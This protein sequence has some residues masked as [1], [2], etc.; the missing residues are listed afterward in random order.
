M[1]ALALGV[2]LA[3]AALLFVVLNVGQPWMKGHV[4]G[5]VADATGLDV[6][7]RD[8]SLSFPHEL[9]V[10]GLVVRSPAQVRAHAPALLRSGTVR[11][12][13]AWAGTTASLRALSADAV[14]LALVTDE[15]GRSSL[16]FVGAPSREPAS[17]LSRQLEELLSRLPAERVRLADVTLEHVRVERGSVVERDVAEHLALE[18]TLE[19]RATGGPKLR[20]RLSAPALVLRRALHAATE[21][22]ASLTASLRLEATG[23][24]AD[25]ALEVHLTRQT[26]STEVPQALHA[27]LVARAAFDPKRA[28]TTVQLAKLVVGQGVMTAQAALE[29]PDAG[30]AVITSTQGE[31]DVPRLLALLPAWLVPLQVERGQLRFRTPALQ[32][33]APVPSVVE[34]E[35][36]LS[37]LRMPLA[38]DSLT[39]ERIELDLR[40]R[41]QDA[42]MR[43]EGDMLVSRA[44][45]EGTEL[46]L[47][48]ETLALSVAVAWDADFALTGS[49]ELRFPTLRARRPQRL[50]VR[51]GAIRLESR[52]L[53][54]ARQAP[55]ALRGE[56]ALVRVTAARLHVVSDE[57]VLLEGVPLRWELGLH[58]TALDPQ[59]LGHARGHARSKLALGG[60]QAALEADAR[61]GAV[62]YRLTARLDRLGELRAL[63]SRAREASLGEELGVEVSSE[64]RVTQLAS[65]APELGHET[66]VR[67]MRVVLAGYAADSATLHARSRG[68][69]QHHEGEATLRV[70]ALT[71]R[72]APARDVALAASATLDA[73]A[74]SLALRLH[75]REPATASLR[76]SLVLAPGDVVDY[77]A[78][79]EASDLAA[80]SALL[81]G[82]LAAL[83]LS[84][85]R[86]AF[87]SAGSVRGVI[88]QG[89]APADLLERLGGRGRA[90]LTV[91][92][93][94]WA[95]GELTVRIREARVKTVFARDGELRTVDTELEVPSAVARSG[96]HRV[97]L[98]DMR[99]RSVASLRG[100]MQRGTLEV[101]Q[102]MSVRAVEQDLVPGFPVGELTWKVRGSRGAD[103][104]IK[105]SQ[106]ELHNRMGG[107]ALKA[108]GGLDM[109]GEQTRL[110]LRA[111]LEQELRPVAALQSIAARGKM[112]L[113]VAVASPNLRVF[114]T[115]SV[116]AL[117][118]A[119][120]A[121][122]SP[123][124]A[125][126]GMEGEIPI[127]V[128]FT[129]SRGGARL[130]RGVPVNPYAALRYADQHPMLAQRSFI[131]IR[132]VATPFGVV[133]PFAANLGVQQNVVSL[134]QMELGVRGGTVTGSSVLDYAGADSRLEVN[135]RASE[136]RSSHGEPFDG[137]AALLVD[138][139]EHSVRGRADILRIG[140][141]HLLDILDL[142]D[143]SHT[144][145]AIERIR[146][147][148]RF[149]YPERV[150]ISFKHGFVNA[151][152]TLGGFAR[153]MRIDDVKGIP[154]GPLMERAMTSMRAAE[155]P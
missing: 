74:S 141:R 79:G 89:P 54:V 127:V 33:A 57:G 140:R 99:D 35:G 124:V 60:L 154:V 23:R 49:A 66:E 107:T 96:P 131:S 137:N 94:H 92:D 59:R 139:A 40:A 128:D 6:D 44:L 114:H 102:D 84:A 26:F 117:H 43:V 135:L 55:L 64:G 12:T 97:A 18:A 134:S 13:L 32:L 21:Q 34:V 133:A 130:L 22:T 37:G 115:S 56:L 106:L 112:G 144:D 16:D 120:L 95:E 104:V 88:G 15:H 122:E 72:G 3:G 27:E 29:L 111:H 9:V 80:L 138:F 149:G 118:D 25:V 36:E 101:A 77:D 136:V 50:D 71:A 103:G 121:L 100:D 93:V 5:L 24:A 81:P 91:H 116:L 30:A 75:T 67:L 69:A 39:L 70:R 47:E 53:A 45:L 31:V 123:A 8:L 129:L 1:G 142:Q 85:L 76:A 41:P 146:T 86:L 119:H 150:R 87:R 148:L 105:L 82:D 108:S 42:G 52:A 78:E 73:A 28:R 143:P 145:P 65:R 68:S 19:P 147:G 151:G 4:R 90:E 48:G 153:F 14:H 98:T 51:D 17:P 62:D 132:R 109:S 38:D 125:L 110:S 58:D 7:Y 126:E 83:D 155:G 46:A 61:G 11:A 152:V 63:A 20:A 10:H 113:D 2:V